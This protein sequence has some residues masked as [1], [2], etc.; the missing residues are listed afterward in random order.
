MLRP[1]RLCRHRLLGALLLLAVAPDT[2]PADAGGFRVRPYLQSP[3]AD[4]VTIAWLSVVDEPG[5]VALYEADDAAP[6]AVLSSTPQAATALAYPEWEATQFYGG[7]PPGMPYSHRVRLS[8]LRPRSTYRYTVTQGTE[9]STSTFTTAPA[10]G[11]GQVRIVFFADCETE[12]ES[13]G[14]RVEWAD[15]ADPG[16]PRRYLLDQTQG[17]ANNLAVILE[18][19]PDLLVLSGDL[20]ESGGEQ[21]DWD[22]FWRHFTDVGGIDLAGR[23]PLLAAPGNHEYYEGPS[24]GRYDQPGS[25]RAIARF[26]SYFDAPGTQATE[27]AERSR[28]GRLDYGPVTLIALDVTNG[29]PHRSAGDTNYFLLG[30][31][32]DGGGRSPGFAPGSAQYAWLE[33]QLADARQRSPFTFVVFHHVP[34][35]VGPHGW[36]AGDGDGQDTQSGTP[37]RA[38]T[39]LFLRYGVDAVIAGHDEI[40]ERSQVPGQSLDADGVSRPHTLQVY[41]VGTAGDGLRGPERELPNPYRAFLAHDDAPEVWRDGVLLSGGKHYGHLEVDVLESREGGWQA[42]LKPA[43]V[44]PLV[45]ASGTYLGCERR[46]YDD[47]VTLTRGP[48]PTAVAQGNTGGPAAFGFEPA[49]PNP[50]NATVLLRF[51]LQEEGPVRLDVFDALG[52]RVRRLVDR[53]LPLGDHAVEWDARDSLGAAVGS[54]VYLFALQADARRDTVEATLVR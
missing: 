6:R 33:A 38:L 43:Y 20:V 29:T 25:E 30:A 5:A 45:D 12:P 51:R 52:Q 18:R 8:G 44:F 46:L 40:W 7:D 47:I 13:T 16:S 37:V 49:H 54:G 53:R 31:G 24:M 39:P 41:D 15:P 50:F 1:E 42:V 35:S 26:L 11:S 34:Y 4:A 21:R 27:P 3:A 48:I 14:A 19:Q 32:D 17:L 28:Y 10:P 22:E 23:V 2:S 9:T 36:P